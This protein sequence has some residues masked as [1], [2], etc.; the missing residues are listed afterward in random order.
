[1]TYEQLSD[2]VMAQLKSKASDIGVDTNSIIEGGR[3]VI[4]PSIN[5]FIS[6]DIDLQEI[7]SPANPP[8]F[9]GCKIE[10]VCLSP[11]FTG[12][13]KARRNAFRLCVNASASLF[14]LPYINDLISIEFAQTNADASVCVSTLSTM[15]ELL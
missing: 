12:E 13:D 3:E 11:S 15:I 4:A 5:V 6:P 2:A 10:L 9:L 8:D 14:E 7:K 1:M